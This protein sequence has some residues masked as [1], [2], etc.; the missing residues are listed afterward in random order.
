MANFN[1]GSVRLSGCDTGKLRGQFCIQSMFAWIVMI[2]SIAIFSSSSEAQNNAGSADAS[3]GI[4][5]GTLKNLDEIVVPAMRANRNDV[6]MAAMT[7]IIDRCNRE[8]L[9]AVEK[10]CESK[11]VGSVRERFGDLALLQIEQGQ[12]NLNAKL[13]M[14]LAVYLADELARKVESGLEVLDLHQVMIDPLEVPEDWLQSEQLFWETHV[15]RNEFLNA[16]RLVDYGVAV[17]KPHFRR[18]Q[19]SGDPEMLAVF[20]RVEKLAALVPETFRTMVERDSE[21]RLIRFNRSHQELLDGG[22]FEKLLIAAM[23]MELDAEQLTELYQDNSPESFTRVAL[24][25]PN[26]SK[27]IQK[28]LKEG[29]Q[30]GD[31]VSLKAILLR[32]GLHFWLRGRYGEG[33]LANGLLKSPE[34]MTSTLAME[35]LYMPKKRP[36][37]ISDYHDNESSEP[38]YDRRHYYTWAVEHRPLI[39]ERS[40]RRDSATT[41]DLPGTSRI[42]RFW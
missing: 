33:Q 22:D 36:R 15:F 37:P 12:I 2:A 17:L 40:S 30:V 42:G 7:D 29:R 39:E 28:K 16:Q 35:G 3:D 11:G 1:F 20:Q 8:Q 23:C 34:A 21:L 9:D 38:G 13:D 31:D 25:D 24:Q 14:G 27:T 26:L 32:S 41:K 6:F 19:K 18:A 10:Y 5:R 4:P